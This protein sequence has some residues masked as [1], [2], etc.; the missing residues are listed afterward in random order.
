MTIRDLLDAEQFRELRA[1]RDQ[2]EAGP[3][4]EQLEI[5]DELRQEWD[6]KG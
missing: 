1:I 4:Q 6:E 2:V 5:T 3:S